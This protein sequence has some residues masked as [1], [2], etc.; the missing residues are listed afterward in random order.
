MWLYNIETVYVVTNDGRLFVG[1]LKGFDQTTNLILEQTQERLFSL[2]DG[3]IMESIGLYI[4]RGDNISLVG[5][6]DLAK[7]ASIDWAEIRAEPIPSI[8][9]W[10]YTS[11]NWM[12]VYA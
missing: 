3:V 2:E 1:T 8:V 4:V 12:N 5:E 11:L 6:L 10:N 7:D 9:H